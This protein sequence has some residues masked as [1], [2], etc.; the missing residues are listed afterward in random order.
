MTIHQC[1]FAQGGV[2]DHRVMFGGGHVYATL[3]NSDKSLRL[4]NEFDTESNL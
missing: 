1:W 2:F 4:Q 3:Q